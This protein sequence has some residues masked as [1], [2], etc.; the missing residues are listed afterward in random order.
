V[1]SDYGLTLQTAQKAKP[2][3][4]PH[5]HFDVEA[6]TSIP[7][8][9]SARKYSVFPALYTY[10]AALFPRPHKNHFPCTFLTVPIAVAAIT[11][12]I[13][14]VIIIV[15]RSGGNNFFVH[16]SPFWTDVPGGRSPSFC[17]PSNKP[18]INDRSRAATPAPIEAQ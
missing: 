11:Y 9:P 7:Q 15:Q 12:A 4:Q 5:W 6:E 2:H 3:A 13:K 14:T 17:Y 18:R 8:P 16:F 10:A 1:A